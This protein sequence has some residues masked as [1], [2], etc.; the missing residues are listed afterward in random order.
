M[1]DLEQ[2]KIGLADS[3]I[4]RNGDYGTKTFNQHLTPGSEKNTMELVLGLIGGALVLA[5]LI[6]ILVCCLKK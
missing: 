3:D 5:L 1:Y 6:V 4:I 2:N